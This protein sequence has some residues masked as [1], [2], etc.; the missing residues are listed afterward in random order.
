MYLVMLTNNRKA[1]VDRPRARR[2][3]LKKKILFI[4]GERYECDRED[5]ERQGV[6]EKYFETGGRS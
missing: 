3:Q 5:H 4:I 2:L 1:W 6:Q